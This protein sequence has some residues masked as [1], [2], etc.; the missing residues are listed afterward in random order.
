MADR[1]VVEFDGDAKGLISTTNLATKSISDFDKKSGKSLNNFDNSLKSVGN[2]AAKSGSQIKASNTNYLNFGR[3]IQDLPFGLIGIQNN[4]TQLIP[5]VGL[6]GLGFSVAVSALTF[7]QVGTDNWTRGLTGNKK[8]VDALT[9]SGDEYANTL[10]A[11]RQATLKGSQEAQNDLVTLKALYGVYTNANL[12][13][14]ERKQAYKEIQDLYPDYFKNIKFEQ[15]ASVKTTTAYN[16][17]TTAIIASARARASAAKITENETRRLENEQKIID[18]EAKILKERQA[19]IKLENQ[20]QGQRAAGSGG[21]GSS[22]GIGLADLKARSEAKVLPFLKQA[23]DLRTD[24]NKLT[25]QNINLIK[26]IQS[27]LKTTGSSLTGSVGNL[28][29]VEKAGKKLK[30][31]ADIMKEL[32]IDL[33]QTEAK[34]DTTFDEKRAA[35]INDYQK[36]IDNLIAN[37]YNKASDAVQ[38][39][40]NKQEELLNNL[41]NRGGNL[42]DVTGQVKASD[43]TGAL[44]FKNATVDFTNAKTTLPPPDLSQFQL[45]FNAAIKNM[46]GNILYSLMNIG[47]QGA[48]VFTNIA[49]LLVHSFDDIFVEKISTA[50]QQLSTDG[51]TSVEGLGYAIAGVLGGII[52]G[53]GVAGKKGNVALKTLGGAVSG[54]AA[55]ALAGSVVPGI[56][57]ALGAVVGGL[58]GGIGGLFKGKQQQKQAEIQAKQL[59]EA[60]KQTKLLER[61]N[62]LAYTASIIGRMTNQGIVTGVEVNEFGDLTTRIAGQDL[63]IVLKRAR[64]S[65]NR[66]V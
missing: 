40:I 34:F 48:S 32:N 60:E 28:N 30:S 11:V 22:L 35:N 5:S 25:A 61:Q 18:L 21:T 12:P 55:V 29:E 4:L 62:A 58:F 10:E 50:F 14:K 37:G 33:A 57:T 17:L 65:S 63:E 64:R 42:A 38:N 43:V 44:T 53:L 2:A 52:S 39:L 3:V 6:L 16:L 66:G 13:L 41:K 23:N 7:L 8:A 24:G 45:S 31:L 26:N 51:A 46:S 49:D 15:E 47:E 20:S 59:Q 27:E 1:I 36:A 54:A 19:I 56:G 9:L